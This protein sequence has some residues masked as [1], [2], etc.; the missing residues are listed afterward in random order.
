MKFKYSILISMAFL[1]A[2]CTNVDVNREPNWTSEGSD[3]SEVLVFR[4]KK[5]WYGRVESGFGST[6]NYVVALKN[7][8]YS[9]VPVPVG[10]NIFQVIGAGGSPPYKFDMSITDDERKCIEIRGNSASMSMILVPIIGFMIPSFIASE[11][12]CPSGD[13]L[14][15]YELISPTL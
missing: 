10:E 12:E 6:E 2:G 9:V 5:W 3:L 13:Q 14:S 11:V 8:Q 7:N 4:G 1:F 15:E